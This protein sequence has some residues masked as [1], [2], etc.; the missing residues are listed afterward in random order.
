MALP[1]TV[2]AGWLGITQAQLSRVEN[3]PPLV[4]LDRLAHWA[5][6]LRIPAPCLWFRLPDQQ[7]WPVA[8]H[9]NRR[10]EGAHGGDRVVE[11][12]EQAV[13]AA[14]VEQASSQGGGTTD[15][16][17]FTVLAALAGLAASGHTYL[18]PGS[19]AE[20]PG[21]I[22]ME[23]VRLASSLVDDLRRADAA[24]GADLLCDVAMHAHSR[25]SA[26]A[27]RSSYGREVGDALQ[28][29][30]AD[31]AI[32]AAWLA[33]DADRRSEARPY[34][35]EAITRARIADDPQVEVR[36]HTHLSLLIRESQPGESLHCA[37]AA[38]RVSAGWATPR[39]TTLLHLR[40]AHAYAV[41]RD[42]SGFSREMTK[43][44]RE[45]ERG[46]HEDDQ[47]FVHFVNA[48]EL[49]GIEGLSYLALGRPE[50]A[51]Q[52]LR[53][54]TAN[55][56][57]GHRR[58]QV[59]YTVRLS[60]AAYQQGDINEAARVALDVLPAVREINSKRVSQH[61]AQVRGSLAAPQRATR[62][63]RQFVDAY[64]QAALA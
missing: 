30:L 15:R 51:V 14:N 62:A 13:V 33:I 12:G 57:P 52:S 22:G 43:A 53:A 63:S 3:G 42:A 58:N 8:S 48:Q 17:R 56:S 19:S 31:L 28:S 27:A 38:L 40:R 50:R 61:L 47:S 1:Q 2:V 46:T 29:A 32:E 23:Q 20:V 49:E 11:R 45:L 59:Y 9:V 24:A 16:R 60:E 26:W 7:S 41:L 36:A 4:H 54:I 6:L 44:R 39:L 55:P 37:E 10:A 64:D 18:L 5:T 35:H 25:L 21:N 34:L